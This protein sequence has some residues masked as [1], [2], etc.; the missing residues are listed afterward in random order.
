MFVTCRLHKCLQDERNV[1][2]DR[3]SQADSFHVIK[4][5]EHIKLDGRFYI[6]LTGEATLCT[7]A[8]DKSAMVSHSL[9]HSLTH[10]MLSISVI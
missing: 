8:S 10:S 5:Y 4:P 6:L 2:L 3:L 9:T 7:D 1:F